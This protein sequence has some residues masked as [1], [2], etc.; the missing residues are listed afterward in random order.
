MARKWFANACAILLLA[1]CQTLKPGDLLFHVVEQGNAIT[2]VTP[3]M[4]DHVAIVLSKDSVIEAVSTG[5]KTTPLD[6]L[7]QQKGYYIIGRVRKVDAAQSVAN[8]RQ[9]LGRKYDRLYL[10]TTRK[11]TVQNWCSSLS[12]I[13]KGSVYSPRFRCRFTMHRGASRT[14]GQSS[15]D[16]TT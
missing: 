4:I 16:S 13:P 6:S 3:G 15:I 1:S 14:T 8:A 9:Y 5:V 7:R 10:P 12:S 11:S 2:D